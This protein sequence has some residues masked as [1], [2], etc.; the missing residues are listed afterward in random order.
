MPTAIGVT[1]GPLTLTQLGRPIAFE[2]E[3]I[4]KGQRST[5][6]A[7]IFE[8]RGDN[9]D[10]EIADVAFDNGSRDVRM[11]SRRDHESL[12]RLVHGLRVG[13]HRT[14][15]D[16]WFAQLR[17]P[18]VGSRG[19]ETFHQ[20]DLESLTDVCRF[21]V[22][23]PLVG[24]GAITVNRRELAIGDNRRA[25]NELCATFDREDSLVPVVAYA[26]TPLFT[27]AA[28]FC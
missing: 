12:D 4:I 1:V 8:V 20:T 23:E 21:D 13:V 16:R 10:V 2:G 5:G 27:Y 3:T 28:Q 14:T 7:R 22:K 11:T 17:V 6:L 9:F 25:R 19:T 15:N 24:A 26:V 18:A